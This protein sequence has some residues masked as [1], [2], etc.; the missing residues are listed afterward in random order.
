MFMATG[1]TCTAI[2][3]DNMSGK[4]TVPVPDDACPMLVSWEIL[5]A[6]LFTK[7]EN[8]LHSGKGSKKKIGIGY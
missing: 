6:M 7:K 5:P 1:S 2:P 8:P 4:R 3:M